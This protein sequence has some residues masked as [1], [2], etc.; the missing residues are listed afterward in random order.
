MKPIFKKLQDPIKAMESK[1]RPK[2]LEDP[3][4]QIE[5]D[6]QRERIKQFVSREYVLRS[7]MEKLYGLLW[8]Q[9]SSALQAT[10]K[11]INEY[12]DKSDDF[13]PIWL[14]I[15]IKKAISGIDLKAN[16]RLTLHEAVSTLYKMKQGETEAN[17]NYLERFKSNIMTVELTGGKD[18][19]C[20]KGIMTKDDDDPTDDE[21]KAEEDKMQDIF[22]LKNAD[23]KRYG[24]L[25]K[26]LKE[27]SFLARDEYP[28][29]IASMYELMVKYSAQNNTNNNINRDDRRRGGLLLTQLGEDNSGEIVPGS[30]GITIVDKKCFRCNKFG[31]IV[32]KCTLDEAPIQSRKGV[33]MLQQGVSLFQKYNTDEVISKTWILLDSC[34]TDTVFKNPDLVANIRT[35][36]ADE[37]L[38]C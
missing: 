37:E 12:E 11:G 28:I 26:S 2:S 3:A 34:S 31:H 13:D 18:F 32:W 35:G 38:K 4:D 19:F 25:S 27:G 22:L 7:N 30:D 20:S 9:C 8:G 21:I 15:E 10:I 23:E 6:I 17:D 33:G 14:L 1:H 24:G 29:S 36:T 5:K 16:P